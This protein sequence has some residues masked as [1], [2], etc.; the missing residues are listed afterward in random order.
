M[1]YLR[2]TGGI[3][4]YNI[5]G[6]YAQATA[7]GAPGE[8]MTG[9]L[10]TGG[11]A[12]ASVAGYLG[13]YTFYVNGW[14]VNVWNGNPAQSILEA[15]TANSRW[16]TTLN[17]VVTPSDAATLALRVPPELPGFCGVNALTMFSMT[18]ANGSYKGTAANA[19]ADFQAFMN[20]SGQLIPLNVYTA[21]PLP[22]K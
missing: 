17:R 4:V 8:I 10:P 20:E 15:T 6:T 1:Y 3:T 13:G 14:N 21:Q 22:R 2:S 5:Y 11:T 16:H 7:G 19:A 9:G 12:T 18:D